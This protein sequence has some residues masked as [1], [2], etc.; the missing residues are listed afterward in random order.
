MATPG[1]EWLL[2]L[3]DILISRRRLIGDD[4]GMSR[5]GGLAIA[6]RTTQPDGL[7]TADALRTKIRVASIRVLI[8]LT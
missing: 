6:S 4:G 3:I 8:E 2:G 1:H 5:P 7:T